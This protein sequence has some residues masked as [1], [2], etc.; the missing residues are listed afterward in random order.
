MVVAFGTLWDRGWALICFGTAVNCDRNTHRA[1][2]HTIE[3]SSRSIYSKIEVSSRLI[4]NVFEYTCQNI[5]L[6][7]FAMHPYR[8]RTL[9]GEGSKREQL[10]LRSRLYEIRV[11]MF[12]V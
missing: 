12:T 1:Q 10:I 6:N 8:L 3:V 2:Y 7:L 9:V 4:M 5:R 11:R